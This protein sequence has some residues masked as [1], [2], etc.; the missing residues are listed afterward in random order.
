MMKLELIAPF[1]VVAA[2]LALSPGVP[3]V[4][5]TPPN[6]LIAT[7]SGGPS[8]SMFK[9]KARNMIRAISVAYTRDANADLIVHMISYRDRATDQANNA[10]QRS[11]DVRTLQMRQIAEQIA[12]GQTKELKAM[13]D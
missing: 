5:A 9:R 8:I 1:A 13:K 4:A 6:R 11:D 10:S 2:T 3:D 12:T 7:E